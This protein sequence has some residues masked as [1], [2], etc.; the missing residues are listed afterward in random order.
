MV[1]ER[2]TGMV[3]RR[4]DAGVVERVDVAAFREEVEWL[5]G[6]PTRH[7]TSAAYGTAVDRVAARMVA[8]GYQTRRQQISVGA[9]SSQNVIGER[10]GADDGVVLVTAHLDSVNHV[11]GPAGA[12][13]GADDNASGAAGVLELGR[14][15]AS[16]SW[17]HGVRLIL[18]GGEEQGLFGSK[19]YVAALPPAERNRI[20]AV[21]NLDM[22]ATRN[23]TTPTVLLEGA[24]LSQ[25]LITTLANA[26]ATYTGLTVETSLHPFASDHVPFLN[27]G[28]P[29]V[30]TIE[31][32]DSANANIHTANDTLNHLDWAYAADILRMNAAA[33]ATWL[34]PIPR[35][36]PA[37]PIVSWG[38]GRIDIFTTG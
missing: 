16:G 18:F 38:P 11:G 26:A 23:T 30:L 10:A 24:A 20:R 33:L 22:I 34:E 17:R 14:V 36:R 6:L 1:V 27:A 29:A 25:S 35:P 12:A 8:M 15:L 37:G 21:L 7:S 13:P 28:I 4:E 2:V 19:Q 31:G 9:K 3:G 32:G 5:A